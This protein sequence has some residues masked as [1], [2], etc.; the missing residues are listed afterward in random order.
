MFKNKLI[1]LP[2]SVNSPHI[3]TYY[4]KTLP[5]VAKMVSSDVKNGLST[6]EA[7]ARLEA[8]GYNSLPTKKPKSL[9]VK[10]L[11]QFADLMIIILLVSALISF[12]LALYSKDKGDLLETFI[13]VGIVLINAVLGTVQEHKAE[14]SLLNLSKLTA[15]TAKVQRGGK[16]YEIPSSEVVVGDVILLEAGDIIAADSRLITGVNFRVNESALTGESM[17]IY[18]DPFKAIAAA[19]PLSG[20]LNTIYGGTFVTNG[21][22]TALVTA[23]ASDTE[24]G[25]IAGLLVG[26]EQA[27]T[28]LQNRLNEL[29][30]AIGFICLAV[31]ILVAVVG[32]VKGIKAMSPTDKLTDVFMNLF[33]TSVSLAVAA[34]PEGLPAVVTIVL[35]RGIEKMVSHNAIVKTLPAVETLGSATVICTDKTGTLTQN[36]MTVSHLCDEKACYNGHFPP[37]ERQLLQHFAYCCDAVRTNDGVFIGDPTEIA[38]VEAAYQHNIATKVSRLFELPF[39]S[40]RKMMTVVVN[41]NGQL[42]SVT[43]GSFEQMNRAS[44]NGAAFFA[45]YKA[46]SKKGFRVLALSVK[47]VAQAFPRNSSLESNL[48]LTGLIALNDPPREGVSRSVALCKT[49][50][51][52][53]VMITGDNIDTATEIAKT[54]GIMGDNDVA[55]DG[56][57]L[58]NWSDAELAKNVRKIAVY[59][60]VTP[61]DKLRIVKAWQSLGEVVAMTGDGVNDAPALKKADIGCAMGKTGTEVAK[62]TADLILTDDDFSTIVEAVAVGRGVYD[63]IKKTVKY[64]LSCNIG[65]VLC[66][67]VCLLIYNVTPLFAIQLLW[68][69]LVTDGLPGLALGMEK[70]EP[71]IMQRKPKARSESFMSN[72]QGKVIAVYGAMFGAI[73][74]VAYAI[75]AKIDAVSGTTMAFLVLAT[76]QLFFALEMRS[77]HSSFMAPLSPFMLISFVVSLFLVWIVA[78]VPAFVNIFQLTHLPVGMYFAALML[79]AVPAVVKEVRYLGLYIARKTNLR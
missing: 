27:K 44:S 16:I 37:A 79:S 55:V 7:A 9:L 31:C 50:G 62:D 53:P 45:A 58:G 77:S 8:N 32:F 30:K 5:V 46:M 41:V 10:F 47:C 61:Y 67:F 12:I 21:H 73:T 2:K 33:M 35:A 15:P 43:K 70:R 1:S 6:A 78:L 24:M 19:T 69:N 42:L 75:G 40:D 63:N 34:I 13:I 71:D 38:I 3:D 64:L 20:R 26:T 74:I 56:V 68:V 25:K 59:A 23:T 60:R 72:G 76:S 22:G 17:P 29:S 54:I 14:R 66:V 57:T 48:H 4:D 65:E 11:S 49:A 39:D 36:K 28:P 18:K 51:I 52:R